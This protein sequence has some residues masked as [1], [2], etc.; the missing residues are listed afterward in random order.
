MH[1]VRLLE[2]VYPPPGLELD[3]GEVATGAGG[4]VVLEHVALG[5][6]QTVPAISLLYV[7]IFHLLYSQFQFSTGCVPTCHNAR[8]I[9]YCLQTRFS[10]C[11]QYLIQ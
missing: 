1:V 2:K 8:V 9:E 7:N 3:V 10:S 6:Q 4:G 5:T 11:P